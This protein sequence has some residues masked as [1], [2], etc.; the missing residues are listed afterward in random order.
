MNKLNIIY[1]ILLFLI[2]TSVFTNNLQNWDDSMEKTQKEIF[3]V[4]TFAEDSD[5]PWGMTF[6]PNKDLIVSD[7]NGNLWQINY[8]S[9]IKN[10]ISGVPKVRYKGQG[11]LL[12]I[13]VHP[14]FIDNNFL[15]II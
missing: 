1:G 9:K 10:K 5:V 15:Y 13:E 8:K 3:R 7:R 4:E 12:D 6:L 11:G 14:D 2:P